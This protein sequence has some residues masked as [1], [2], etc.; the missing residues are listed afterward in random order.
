MSGLL[1]VEGLTAGYGGAPVVREIRL[2]ADAGRVVSVLGPNGSGKSTLLKAIMG[3]VQVSAG[4]VEIDGTDVTG[5]ATHKIVRRGIGYV[6][7]I[8]N[9]FAS[10]SIVEN[11]E[12]GAFAFDGDVSEAVEEVLGAFPDLR[13]ARSKKAGN[14]SGGQRNLL[15]LARALTLR[16][17]VILVDEP[18]AGLSP[19]NARRIWEQLAMTAANGTGVLVVEQNVEIAVRG[20][21]WCCVL[22]NGKVRLSRAADAIAPDELHELFLGGV[23]SRESVEDVT[24]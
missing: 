13:A 4:A 8:S 15:G 5:Q 1:R 14:L 23:G 11:L 7:Q 17:S 19:T 24:L 18:T 3:L 12:M 16:P 20:S 9:V 10:L 21:D 6:P 2:E 22:V